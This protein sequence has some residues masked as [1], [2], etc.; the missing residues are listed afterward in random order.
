MLDATNPTEPPLPPEGLGERARGR[1]S[2][3]LAVSRGASRLVDLAMSGSAR[4]LLPHVEGPCPEAVFLNTAGGLTSGDALGFG[5]DLAPAATL[6]ATTQT[7]ER[8]YLAPQ[9]PARLSVTATLGAGATVHWLPQETILFQG[10]DLCRET[11]IELGTGAR[12]LLVETVVLGR[13]AMG[14]TVTRA[15]LRD[16]RRVT[17]LGRP[18]H[19]EALELTPEA[20]ARAASPALLGPA[21]AFASLAFCGPGAEGA[22]AAVQDLPAPAEV[23]TAASGWN[24]RTLMRATACDLWPLK[25][26][27][28]RVIARL[29][30]QPLPRV[31][32]MNGAPS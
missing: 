14:E 32:Q 6:N 12:C 30:G 10:A 17:V 24:G 15:R 29:T 28:G 23:T 8:A 11:R 3:S 27:L 9:G 25:L 20:L 13:R 1:A 21:I 4:I 19:T 31:W 16:L 26:Y 7:A 2:L 18:L 22:A 5:I